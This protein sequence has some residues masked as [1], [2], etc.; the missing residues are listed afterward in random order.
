[1]SWERILVNLLL[2]AAQAMPA[3]G[4]VK[5]TAEARGSSATIR[6]EDNGPGIPREILARIFEA[7]F[8]TKPANSGMG[9]HI[10]RSL[11]EQDHGTVS[12]VNRDEGGA[13]FVIE[14]RC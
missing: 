12:V 6:L 11:V 9:L 1:M 14:A 3:G 2:N 7:H 8:S 5:L 4:W 13:S 10:V